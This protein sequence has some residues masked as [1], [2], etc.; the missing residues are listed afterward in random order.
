MLYTELSALGAFGAQVWFAFCSGHCPT[1]SE[2]GWVGDSGRIHQSQRK[3]GGESGPK[4]ITL[5]QCGFEVHTR[6]RARQDWDV[7]MTGML[8]GKGCHR[9]Q[10]PVVL[11]REAPGSHGSNLNICLSLKEFYSVLFYSKY[12]I[13]I[14]C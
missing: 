8:S 14:G 6:H 1:G 11:A 13:L 12:F 3:Q 7:T 10:G 5:L 4:S 2:Q 9:E